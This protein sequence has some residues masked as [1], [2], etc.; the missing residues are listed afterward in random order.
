MNEVVL[1][2]RKAKNDCIIVMRSD[3]SKNSTKFPPKKEAM[4]K[5]L[6]TVRPSEDSHME[7]HTKTTV[8]LAVT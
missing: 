4:A 1:I 3:E 7:M 8:P 5:W 6:M 2:D